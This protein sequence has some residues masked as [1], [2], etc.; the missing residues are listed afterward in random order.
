MITRSAAGSISL[1]FKNLMLGDSEQ[2]GRQGGAARHCSKTLAEVEEGLPPT[3]AEVEL[4]GRI[5][6]KLKAIIR[7]CFNGWT[8][9]S[10]YGIRQY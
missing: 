2:G 4:K 8:V 10:R 3:L 1:D 5:I 9:E 6:I 7:M